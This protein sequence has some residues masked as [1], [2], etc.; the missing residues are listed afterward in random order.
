MKTY[1]NPM[2]EILTL[3]TEDVI[4]TSVGL[5]NEDSGRATIVSMK[6]GFNSI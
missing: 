2:M 4:T 5:R 1:I 6:D 3:T